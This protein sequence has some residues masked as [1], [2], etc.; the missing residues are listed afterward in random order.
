MEVKR[1]NGSTFLSLLS[2][3]YGAFLTWGLISAFVPG[4]PYRVLFFDTYWVIVLVG[5][6]IGFRASKHWG[7]T[8]SL[9]GRG[10]LFISF[11]LAGQLFGQLTFSVLYSLHPDGVPYPSI[12]DI[13]YFGSIVLYCVGMWLIAKAAGA[14]FGL[15]DKLGIVKI[16]LVPLILLGFTFYFFVGNIDLDFTEPLTTLLNYAYPIG[17]ALYVTIGILAFLLSNGWL[18]GVLKKSVLITVIA[19]LVQFG[20]DSSFLYLSGKGSWQAGGFNDVL[21]LTSY[22][23]ISL[24]FLN[25]YNAYFHIKHKK[26]AV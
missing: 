11:G 14:E 7:G 8:K 18:G 1:T 20:A 13:G 10:L 24:S 15:R 12:A 25:Y 22:F 6:F 21:Y 2:V 17:Q 9:V 4:F 23:V 3:I 16:V 26:K 5:L 19:L